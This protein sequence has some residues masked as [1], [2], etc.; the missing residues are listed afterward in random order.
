MALLLC[1]SASPPLSV[2]VAM[3]PGNDVTGRLRDTSY[4]VEL[5]S[6][7]VAGLG[8]ADIQSDERVFRG[9]IGQGTKC[10]F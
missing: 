2:C 6:V 8:T 9:V 7:R 5:P 1:F 10:V 4:I 3:C